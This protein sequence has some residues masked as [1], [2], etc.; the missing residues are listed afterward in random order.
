MNYQGALKRSKQEIKP[1]QGHHERL[2]ARCAIVEC[3]Q[4]ESAS[5]SFQSPTSVTTDKAVL[6]SLPTLEKY[7]GLNR[8]QKILGIRFQA[9]L[10]YILYVI[11]V[12]LSCCFSI[13]DQGDVVPLLL[14]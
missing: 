5:V 1:I 11:Y 13:C 7:W 9:P 14:F 10:E 2:L 3:P 4:V 6:S 8:I 12:H